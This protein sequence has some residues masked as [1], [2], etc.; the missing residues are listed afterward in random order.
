MEK[1]LKYKLK[2]GK[3]KK[4]KKR[5]VEHQKKTHGGDKSDT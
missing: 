3:Q 4:N 1:H 2:L 5:K